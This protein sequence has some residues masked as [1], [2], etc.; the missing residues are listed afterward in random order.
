M[1]FGNTSLEK[2]IEVDNKSFNYI[3]WHIWKYLYGLLATSHCTLKT[4]SCTFWHSVNYMKFCNMPEY[5]L[6]IHLIIF[7]FNY[8][9]DI[10]IHNTYLLS[11]YWSNWFYDITSRL[12]IL[13]DDNLFFSWNAILNGRMTVKFIHL[14]YLLSVN[15]IIT[16]N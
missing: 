14:M 16:A 7:S 13:F 3:F 4:P 11:M 12:E 8:V 5:V 15:N 10:L 1:V 2:S 9:I 6:Y